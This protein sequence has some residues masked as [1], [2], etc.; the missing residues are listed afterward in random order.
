MLCKYV[1]YN[2]IDEWTYRAINKIV[3]PF[4]LYTSIRE[5]INTKITLAIRKRYRLN[6]R[7]GSNLPFWEA[8]LRYFNSYRVYEH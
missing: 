7:N 4:Y 8:A 3:L 2:F 5:D 1:K 6:L